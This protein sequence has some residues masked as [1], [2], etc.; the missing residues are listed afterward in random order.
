MEKAT[1]NLELDQTPEPHMQ[2]RSPSS[3]L[4]TLFSRTNPSPTWHPRPPR[5]AREFQHTLNL[6]PSLSPQK[7]YTHYSGHIPE[8]PPAPRKPNQRKMSHSPLLVRT[9]EVPRIRH[10]FEPGVAWEGPS[11]ELA[12]T[13][14]PIRRDG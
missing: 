2:V 12:G 8:T 6:N 11:S 10:V 7:K 9:L 3:H 14:R 13:R 5:L 1:L 4:H